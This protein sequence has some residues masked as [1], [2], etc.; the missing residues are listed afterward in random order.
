[1]K[2]LPIVAALAIN[3]ASCASQPDKIAALSVSSSPYA[4]LGCSQLQSARARE[5]LALAD[6]SAKQ[7]NAATGDALGV[8]LIGLP[9]SSMTGND[10]GPQIA[11]TKG[12]LNAIEKVRVTKRCGA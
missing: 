9:V 11:Q 7:S 3:L 12:R 4:G 10:V 5:A 1:V 2:T 6:L 8:A